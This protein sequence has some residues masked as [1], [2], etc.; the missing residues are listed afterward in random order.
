MCAC[1]LLPSSAVSFSLTKKVL[2]WNVDFRNQRHVYVLVLSTWGLLFSLLEEKV[3]IFKAF[4][5][6]REFDLKASFDGRALGGQLGCLGRSLKM[7][8]KDLQ[9]HHLPV[10]SRLYG[11]WG[12]AKDL[13]IEKKTPSSPEVRL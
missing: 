5:L 3:F 2:S 13:F 6:E 4:L 10:G 1:S 12:G 11:V 7:G 8:G 9:Q